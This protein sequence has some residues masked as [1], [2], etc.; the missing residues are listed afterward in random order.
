MCIPDSVTVIKNN[1]FCGC[2]SL[3]EIPVGRN[4]TVFYDSVYMDCR[5]LTE[6]TVPDHITE[7][8]ANVFRGCTGIA[9][10][11]F[12]RK[13]ILWGMAVFSNCRGLTELDIP[14]V[15]SGVELPE[16]T[17][18]GAGLVRATVPEGIERLG[19]SC[20]CSCYELRNVVLPASLT[21][22]GD[23]C[24]GGCEKLKNGL[25]YL[26]LISPVSGFLSFMF[27]SAGTVLVPYNYIN[28]TWAGYPILRKSS[29]EFTEYQ[30]PRRRI[31]S[32][33][34]ASVTLLYL[35]RPL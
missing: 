31:T 21:A 9:R 7:I 18:N 15:F 2:I 17:F 13:R 25:E 27:T 3:T 30:L 29:P 8:K 20:F 19:V 6:V 1:A 14:H 12:P 32:M 10:I 16:S 28:E 5:N 4:V 26:G 23:Y 24:F 34:M 11:N 35:L 22:F 33:R